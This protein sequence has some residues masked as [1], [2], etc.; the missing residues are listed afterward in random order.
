M[1]RVHHVDVKSV[2][3]QPL[4]FPSVGQ[5][6][7]NVIARH[8][9]DSISNSCSAAIC[10]SSRAHEQLHPP[11]VL[12][13]DISESTPDGLS[14]RSSC[15][16]PTGNVAR[17]HVRP[18]LLRLKTREYH[19]PRMGTLKLNATA[20]WPPSPV[21]RAR[22]LPPHRSFL[23]VY[24]AQ[25]SRGQPISVLTTHTPIILP[26]FNHFDCVEFSIISDRNELKQKFA[27]SVRYQAVEYSF[28]ASVRAA[29]V[30]H[31]LIVA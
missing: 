1:P 2:A 29:G 13:S 21:M 14:G 10:R 4:Q 16:R 6:Q 11:S 25:I 9:P 15:A 28:H 5:E 17:D 30:F 3:L 31:D 7:V 18:T 20:H 22:D 26:T 12:P 8:L 19:P 27:L 24:T 23:L